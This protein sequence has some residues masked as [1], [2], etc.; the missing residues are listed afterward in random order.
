M[1]SLNRA[2][3]LEAHFGVPAAGG[4]LCAI[5]TRLAP[6]EVRFIVGALWRAGAVARSRARG[7]GGP[8]D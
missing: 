7:L 8:G 1:L 4:A 5:N 2:E 6:P 3:L